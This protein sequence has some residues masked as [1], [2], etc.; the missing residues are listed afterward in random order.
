MISTHNSAANSI[1]IG[2]DRSILYLRGTP[3]TGGAIVMAVACAYPR[4]NAST[5]SGAR[6]LHC[7][8]R[9]DGPRLRGA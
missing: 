7:R 1:E 6:I 9:G 3:G 8:R 5:T 2:H 4:M